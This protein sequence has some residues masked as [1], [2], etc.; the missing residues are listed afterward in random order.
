MNYV[1]YYQLPLKIFTKIF[2]LNLK[3][4]FI[5]AQF[6]DW[7]VKAKQG[8]IRFFENTASYENEL[9]KDLYQFNIVEMQKLF[10]NLEIT[11][12]GTFS[13][14][15]YIIKQYL[16]WCVSEQIIPLSNE[17]WLDNFK[18]EN[19][20]IDSLIEKKYFKSF[21]HL[22]CGIDSIIKFVSPT[23]IHQFDIMEISFYL[24]WFGLTA[25]Q[26]CN[27]KQNDIDYKNHCVII[28]N[29]KY[30]IN[31]YVKDLI[32]NYL[33]TDGYYAGILIVKGENEFF[34][35]KYQNTDFLLRR[36]MSSVSE[37]YEPREIQSKFSAYAFKRTQQFDDNNLYKNHKFNLKDI[38]DSGCFCRL[39]EYTQETGTDISNLDIDT[40]K[41]IL[42]VTD[43]SSSKRTNLIA[44]FNNWETTFQIN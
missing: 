14:R 15:K 18:Y 3:V 21:E 26:I 33:K 30:Y 20:S 36:L 35:R 41:N 13:N 39:Y 5:E 6:K 17:E 2:H 29:R 19:F 27:L 40:M 4:A 1:E 22:K 37:N 9:G 32:Y 43:L 34:D 44:I 16:D 7:D 28:D 23:D 12:K 11:T 10:V 25:K 42:L 31:E 24:S 38:Y 8:I